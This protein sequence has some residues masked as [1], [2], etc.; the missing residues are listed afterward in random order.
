MSAV[1][2]EWVSEW[3]VNCSCDEMCGEGMRG[4]GGWIAKWVIIDLLLRWLNAWCGCENV[5]ISESI[6]PGLPACHPLSCLYRI[7]ARPD[8]RSLAVWV[9]LN[10]IS[11]VR[12]GF[13]PSLRDDWPPLHSFVITL[14][15]CNCCSAHIWPHDIWLY[16]AAV[17]L[18]RV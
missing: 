18:C 11:F 2:S 4:C 7:S 3:T 6:D 14:V 17:S 15:C 10:H 1:V 16:L 13:C 5:F 12:K 9:W 8:Y